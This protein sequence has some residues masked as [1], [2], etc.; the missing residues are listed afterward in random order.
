MTT[1]PRSEFSFNLQLLHPQISDQREPI[2]GRL[3][4]QDGIRFT[5][6]AL[7]GVVLCL[8]LWLFLLYA[9]ARHF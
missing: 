3:A 7:L 6:G 8:P 2:A 4:V 9:F 1:Q 5:R